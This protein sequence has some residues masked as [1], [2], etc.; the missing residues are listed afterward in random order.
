LAGI[1]VEEISQESSA[2]GGVSARNPCNGKGPTRVHI[3]MAVPPGSRRA[4]TQQ[5]WLAAAL[6]AITEAG[7][8]RDRATNFT[9][10]CRVLAAYMDWST[11]TA[12]PTWRLLCERAGPAPGKPLSRSTVD[13]CLRWLCDV[14]LLG[15]VEH[16]ST[17]RLRP[18]NGVPSLRQPFSR[19]APYIHTGEGNRAAV[20]VLT[21]R[22][23]RRSRT[24]ALS[25]DGEIETP[26]QFCRQNNMDPRAREADARGSAQ[27]Q[28][29]GR[30]SPLE[31]CFT[32]TACSR[33]SPLSRLSPRHLL[34]LVKDHLA[35]GWSEADLRYAL[36]HRRDGRQWPY[37]TEV[38]HPA[39]WVRFRLA[40][41]R[42]DAGCPLPSRTQLAQQRHDA[43]V[44]AHAAL[45]AQRASQPAPDPGKIATVKAI[46][47]A[48]RARHR[49]KRASQR[50]STAAGPQPAPAPAR[51]P[52][53]SP[54][55]GS[56]RRQVLA[57]VPQLPEDVGLLRPAE[58]A[59][60]L[61][62]VRDPVTRHRITGAY[63]ASKRPR[64]GTP[65][66]TAATPVEE[67]PV[68]L[69]PTSTTAGHASP[70]APPSHDLCLAGGDR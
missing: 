25:G 57:V 56:R 29:T 45:M 41:W 11:R 19:P 35:A 48:A 7:W 44:A 59:R 38:R 15:I 34:H 36:D 9:A 42:D 10:I 46:A 21:I 40:A 64:R 1:S 13:R 18:R 26:S 5:E 51:P 6:T 2:H 8:R 63:F 50:R 65:A 58:L 66:A 39:G 49:D 3:A 23:R 28:A 70:A 53:P 68:T 61:L 17:E 31:T 69:Q 32:L 55:P 14:G 12:W 47:A 43:A 60:I 27:P 30:V 16:G 62:V 54:P 20:Y 22:R 52:R 4:R 33:L 37:T 24:P 67:P